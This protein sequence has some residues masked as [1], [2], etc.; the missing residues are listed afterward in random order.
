MVCEIGYQPRGETAVCP[1]N[2]YGASKAQMEE[3]VR[4]A[5]YPGTW[6]MVRAT[7]ICG[8]WF[9]VPYRGFFLAVARGRYRHPAGARVLKSVGYVGNTV[10]QLIG[11]LAAEPSAISPRCIT[12]RTISLQ[13]QHHRR[14]AH[15]PVPEHGQA[16]GRGRG[17]GQRP[18]G[19]R[20]V[21]VRDLG[22]L[23]GLQ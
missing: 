21:Q 10:E 1:P 6:L 13:R 3:L 16:E 22:G 23:D 15:R 18:L 12:S 14:S 9:D 2:A 7:S 8:P 5:A 19:H 4:A 17:E 20:R 11:L